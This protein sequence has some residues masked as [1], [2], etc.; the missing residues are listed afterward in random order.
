MGRIWQEPTNRRVP[1]DEVT[2]R[3]AKRCARVRDLSIRAFTLALRAVPL[4]VGEGYFLMMMIVTGIYACRLRD[5]RL[6]LILIRRQEAAD[7]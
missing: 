1:D 7:N 4:P 3:G 6:P 5:Q 2:E